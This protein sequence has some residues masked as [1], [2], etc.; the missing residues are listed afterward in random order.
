MHEQ[1]K[2]ILDA[3]AAPQHVRFDWKSDERITYTNSRG[4]WNLVTTPLNGDP[5]E[6][7]VHPT[8]SG[9]E[10]ELRCSAGHVEVMRLGPDELRAELEQ[11]LEF[12]H[13][14]TSFMSFGPGSGH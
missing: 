7:S 4:A 1:I 6:I 10:L 11:V 9:C 3:W 8:E 5:D 12:F 13:S 2:A 14:W